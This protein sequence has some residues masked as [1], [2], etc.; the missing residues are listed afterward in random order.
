MIGDAIAGYIGK[1]IDER[2]GEGGTLGAIAG[3]A[4]WRVTK[5]VVPA[6]IVLGA[7]ALGYRYLTRRRDTAPA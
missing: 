3:I 7:A 5:R 6:A 1:R 4:A 2:D